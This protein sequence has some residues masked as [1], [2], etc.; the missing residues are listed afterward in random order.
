MDN[1]PKS[2]TLKG[3]LKFLLRDSIIYG[4]AGAVSKLFALFTFPIMARY[5][6]VE[7]Y[8]I[9]DAFTVLSSLLVTMLVFGQDSAVARYFYEYEDTLERKK[10]V[11]QS[12]SIQFLIIL[13]SLPILLFFANPIS[14][15]YTNEEGLQYL[16][17][18]V[19]WQVPFGLIINFAG[20][21]LKWTFKRF[22]FLFL[23]LGSVFFYVVTVIIAILFFKVGVNEVF[24]LFLVSRIIFGIIG[25]FFIIGWISIRFGTSHYK[26]LIKYGTPY[27]IICIIGALIPALDRLFINKY[28]TP[29][30]LGLYAVAFKIAFLIQL[31]INAFQMAWGPFYLS[32]FKE[33]DAS[34]TYN[35]VLLAFSVLVTTMGLTLILFTRLIIDVLAGS[36]YTDAGSVVF[37]LVM[38][39]VITSIGWILGIGIDL[40]KKSHVKLVS[41]IIRLVTTAV[42]ILVLIKPLGLMGVAFGFLVG[43]IINTIIETWFSYNVYPLRFRLWP[44]V[45]TIVAACLFGLGSLIFFTEKVL[46]QVII[47][48]TILSLFIFFLWYVPLKRRNLITII[49]SML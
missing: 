40:S 7:D 38:G 12:L 36:K 39:M 46:I 29:F 6:S 5:F 16:T 47:N 1:D 42:V 21:V 2:L 8:G 11:S 45:L 37:P 26:A 20:N 17:K 32:L 49:R 31:P 41:A 23:Q 25:L 3:R 19:I 10:V 33:K 34:Q 44:P 27:G 48:I 30:D 9:I 4:G 13:I 18:L 35:S 15:Y 24:L 14:K 22:H 43:Q 28:L